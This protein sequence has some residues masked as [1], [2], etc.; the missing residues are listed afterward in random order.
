MSSLVSTVTNTLAVT[1]TTRVRGLEAFTSSHLWTPYGARGVF[2]GQVV[3]QSLMAAIDTVEGKDLH[4]QHCYFLLPANS[5]API[6]FTVERLRDGASYA[7]RLVHALQDSRTV[8]ILMASFSAPPRKL[9]TDL[10]S[11]TGPAFF[12][13]D[14]EQPAVDNSHD[15]KRDE[16]GITETL[17]F[18][19]IAAKFAA[20]FDPPTNGTSTKPEVQRQPRRAFQPSYQKTMPTDIVPYKDAVT[21]EEIWESFLQRA[22][23]KNVALGSKVRAV[24]N[25]IK[26]RQQSP[27]TIS[28]ARAQSEEYPTTRAIWMRA[29][30]QPGETL[31]PNMVRALIA[32]ATDFQFIGTGARTVGLSGT[33]KPRLG[34]M[35]SIDH[36]LHYY[37][38]PADFDPSAPLLHVMD[39]VQVDVASGRGFVRGCVYT[40]NGYLVASTSQEGVIRADISGKKP[41]MEHKRHQD[42]E[43]ETDKAKL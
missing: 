8:F 3:A 18:D 6:T 21:E 2:G 34:M 16:P 9:P 15:D 7:T 10:V 17:K 33:S 39:A 19:K 37:P 31:T 42:A 35:A 13:P 32:F 20:K 36:C 29:R 41:T 14:S 4:S 27:V 30:L 28:I 24:Q 25:Y 43:N 38:L 23:T 22:K 26:E 1:P 40:E 12:E 5:K 11:P